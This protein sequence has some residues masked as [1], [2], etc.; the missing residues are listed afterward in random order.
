MK[1][2]S[3]D[4]RHKAQQ[5]KIDDRDNIIEE[6]VAA[7][8]SLI[9]QHKDMNGDLRKIGKGRSEDGSDP[10]CPAEKARTALAKAKVTQ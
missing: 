9:W 1:A 6:L 7:L 2:S 4:L 5:Q 8:G 10:Y 3:L